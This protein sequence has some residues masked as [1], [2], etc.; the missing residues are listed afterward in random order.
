MCIAILN[1]PKYVL[2]K[3]TLNNCWENNSDG[4]GMLYIENGVLTSF[5]ELTSFKKYFK[6]YKEA[7]KRNKSSWF[8]LHFRISTHG[9]INETNC[10]P[11]MVNDDLGFVHN[12][13]IGGVGSSP[14]FSD[15]YLFNQTILKSL[16]SGFE[17]NEGIGKLLSDFIDYSK[18]IFLNSKNEWSIIGESKGHWAD[19]NWFSNDTYK[20]VSQYLDYGGTK[21]ARG[22]YK[23]EPYTMN[24]VKAEKSY[25]KNTTDCEWCN[26][27][28]ASYSFDDGC[29][30][31]KEC[32]DY[33]GK[34]SVKV[35]TDKPDLDFYVDIQD[36]RLR[37]EVSYRYNEVY[38]TDESGETIM[39]VDGN[40]VEDLL[41]MT[42]EEVTRYVECTLLYDGY[43]YDYGFN[44]GKDEL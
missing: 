22:S 7:K 32:K 33:F 1:T 8:V 43:D 36:Y 11:F 18:L 15:T 27:N 5:K 35:D 41:K 17:H 30:L 26:D 13:I 2:S 21:I 3:Q 44:D 20:Y 24:P 38:V 40:D 23:Y 39:A 9:K 28:I 19:G 14:D 31:C 29:Y 42:Q 25:K 37:V 6:H 34:P 10:H 12:G 4:A 16:P